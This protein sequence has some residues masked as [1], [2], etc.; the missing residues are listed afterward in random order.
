MKRKRMRMKVEE[1]RQGH[2]KRFFK[3][4]CKKSATSVNSVISATRRL[5]S[6]DAP[7]GISPAAGASVGPAAASTLRWSPSPL[8]F[9]LHCTTRK[10]CSCTLQ[11]EKPTRQDGQRPGAAVPAYRLRLLVTH[12]SEG[13]VLSLAEANKSTN[14]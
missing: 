7:L 11:R 12:R 9:Q 6:P 3:L 8:H 1:S 2:M 13:L 14:K 10:L 4:C 5:F